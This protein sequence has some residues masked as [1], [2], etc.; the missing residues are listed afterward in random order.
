MVHPAEFA[1]AGLACSMMVPM[2]SLGA[3]TVHL[4]TGS[5]HASSPTAR[6]EGFVTIFSEPSS[7]IT[8]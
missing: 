6:S 4:T 7:V 2:N 1:A 3:I 8:R 5:D